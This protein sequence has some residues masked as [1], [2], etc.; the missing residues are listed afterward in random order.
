MKLT[1]RE[2]RIF[3][4]WECLIMPVFIIIV[5]GFPAAYALGLSI[6]GE[7][8]YKGGLFL[9]VWGGLATSAAFYFILLYVKL[10]KEKRLT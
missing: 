1:E 7:L 10:N 8:S 9:F 6:A 5:Y 2:K 3:S 4:S